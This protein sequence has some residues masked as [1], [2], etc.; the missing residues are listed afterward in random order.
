MDW[1]RPAATALSLAILV[2][3]LWRFFRTPPVF[4]ILVQNGV[5]S[6]RRGRVSGR[7]FAEVELICKTW[8][9]PGA[10]SARPGASGARLVFSREIAA[11]H[12]Q[13]FRNVWHLG[14]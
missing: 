7:F 14:E 6:V 13:R 2:A 4:E 8:S 5:P 10:R 9:I 12:H 1:L 3:I 11:E